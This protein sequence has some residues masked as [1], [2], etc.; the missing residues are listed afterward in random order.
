MDITDRLREKDAGRQLVLHSKE[1]L[2]LI[3]SQVVFVGRMDS[4]MDSFVTDDYAKLCDW[5]RYSGF[6]FVSFSAIADDLKYNR[7]T[8]QITDSISYCY[9]NKNIVLPKKFNPAIKV[10]F[11]TETITKKLF[12][13]LDYEHKEVK[14]GLLRLLSDEP[15]ENGNYS[16]EYYQLPEPIDQWNR[17]SL[18]TDYLKDRKFIYAEEEKKEEKQPN[19]VQED[20]EE[21]PRIR[22]HFGPPPYKDA[23]DKI[24]EHIARAQELGIYEELIS[25]IFDVISKTKNLGNGNNL[26]IS[27]LTIDSEYRIFLPDYAN[28]EIEMTVLPKTLF[29]FFLRHPEGIVLKQLSDYE[30]EILQIYKMLSKRMNEQEMRESIKQLCHPTENSVNE[31]ISR[32]KQAFLRQ[33][34]DRNACHYYIAGARGKE[35]KIMLDRKLLRLPA[36]LS[37]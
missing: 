2:G 4:E 37:K 33:I 34:S 16:F 13:K 21:A 3:A 17:L 20:T 27:R 11:S 22:F 1:R 18:F 15:D 31:K 5:F 36:E 25:E 24:E 23:L 8:R 6:D 9:P 10:Y 12:A 19:K 26:Q 28:K 35:Y 14:S 7:S 30:P 32:V 29:V